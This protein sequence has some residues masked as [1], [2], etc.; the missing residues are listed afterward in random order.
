[1]HVAKIVFVSQLATTANCFLTFS[2]SISKD[3]PSSAS[4]LWLQQEG[5]HGSNPPDISVVG[6]DEDLEA[7]RMAF[8]TKG[9]RNVSSY[10]DENDTDRSL[11]YKFEKATGLLK[12]VST[13]AGVDSKE[14]PKWVP[15]VNDMESVLISNGWSFLDPDTSEPMSAFDVDAA[16]AEGTYKPKW[17]LQ[18]KSLADAFILSKL[19][20]DLSPMSSEEIVQAASE[21]INEESLN[22]LLHGGTDNPGKKI[23]ANGVSFAGAAGQQDIENGIFVCAVGSLPLFSTTDLSPLTASSG[24]LTFSRPLSPD[25][26]THIMPE[27]DASD[28]RV[29]VLCAKSGCHLGHFLKE[30]D[31]ASMLAPWPFC[32]YLEMGSVIGSKYSILCPGERLKMSPLIQVINFNAFCRSPL[33]S[34]NL[35]SA[36][37]VSGTSK[38]HCGDYQELSKQQ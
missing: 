3:I 14:F 5:D 10:T 16:N 1:M 17:G 13:P 27:S 2:S 36:A 31:T 8:L 4:I 18:Q 38:Q 22:T 34:R 30:T 28:Q 25:H 15:L 24:W 26:I 6:L 20:F 33:I 32:V 21:I 35:S 7:I 29:E 23:T 19:G 37:A 9:F 11:V 12:L